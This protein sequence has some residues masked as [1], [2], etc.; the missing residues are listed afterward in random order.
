MLRPRERMNRLLMERL[1]TPMA[2][3]LLNAAQ[4]T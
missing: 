1:I 2:G 4:Q 3:Q